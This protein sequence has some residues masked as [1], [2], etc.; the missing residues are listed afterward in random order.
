MITEV[1]MTVKDA[2]AFFPAFEENHW[3]ELSRRELAVS[4]SKFTLREL[5]RRDVASAENV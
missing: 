1:D 3:L 2:D 5:I 4:P